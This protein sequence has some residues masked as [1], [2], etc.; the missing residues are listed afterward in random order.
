MIPDWIARCLFL[1]SFFGLLCLAKMG[2][3]Q[4]YFRIRA[5]AARV[6]GLQSARRGLLWGGQAFGTYDGLRVDVRDVIWVSEPLEKITVELPASVPRD[7]SLHRAPASTRRRAAP[8]REVETGDAVFDARIHV[9]G[10]PAWW[11]LAILDAPTRAKVLRVV[12]AEGFTL[13]KG[14]LTLVSGGTSDAD[15]L[16][17]FL[18]EATTVGH[19]LEPP[20]GGV[21]LDRLARNAR[22]DPVE[23]VRSCCLK[24]QCDAF[25][26]SPL[27]QST[28]RAALCDRSPAIRLQ[29]ARALGAE[30]VAGLED[31]LRHRA[32][33]DPVATA[34]LSTL[35]TLGLPRQTLL[36]HLMALLDSDQQAARCLAIETL[37]RME[38]LPAVD[39]LVALLAEADA[40]TA[41]AVAHALGRLGSV[42]VIPH[43]RAAA[44]RRASDGALRA[45]VKEGV[46]AIR[47]RLRGADAGQ[48]SVSEGVDA[49][50]AV[51][52]ADAGTDARGQ[53]SLG[54]EEVPHAGDAVPSDVISA[55][56]PTRRR[57]RVA[58][59][60]CG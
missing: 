12:G 33:P 42:A 18:R 46:A 40:E 28:C 26:D 35:L 14:R 5:A 52:L 27:T 56:R 45:A 54:I 47:S 8:G 3:R 39:R 43:L 1:G 55:G 30:G 9:R 2:Y 4:G 10:A 50:G 21:I 58:R 17:Q 6:L 15:S 32:C 34:A 44:D 31:L 41:I 23:G 29:A 13:R 37:G 59:G 36:P 53:V 38:H 11:V 57:G 22:E 51:T 48:L 60:S 24:A 25:P 7:L 49:S 20:S 19:A 16:A